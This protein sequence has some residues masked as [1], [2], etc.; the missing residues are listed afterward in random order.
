MIT[1]RSVI[2]DI[3][4]SLKQNFDD[5]ELTLN[6]I[7]YWVTIA[8]N[9][10]LMQHIE[11]RESG[12]FLTIFGGVMVQIEAGTD[13]KYVELPSGIIDFNLDNGVQYMSYDACVDECT[14]PFTSVTFT[15]TSPAAAKILYFTEEEKPTPDNPYFYRVG[16]KIY[17]LGL[18]CIDVCGIEMGLYLTITPYDCSLDDEFPFPVELIAILQRYVFDIGRFVLAMPNFIGVNDG[19][20]ENMSGVQVPKTKLISAQNPVMNPQQQEQIEQ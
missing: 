1:W 10:L 3:Y 2:Y 16:N 13:Y 9:R 4:Q 5:S 8:A 15:R 7:K 12:G 20:S 18:E 11:K 6:H 14:P 17:L 19:T